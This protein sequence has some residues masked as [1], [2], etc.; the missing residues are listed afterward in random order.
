MCSSEKSQG[1][2]QSYQGALTVEAWNWL[3]LLLKPKWYIDNKL[4]DFQQFCSNSKA[5]TLGALWFRKLCVDFQRFQA[6]VFC[7]RAYSKTQ[8]PQ[9]IFRSLFLKVLSLFDFEH[10]PKHFVCSRQS[11]QGVAQSYQGALTVEAWNWLSLLL[12]PKW[13]IDNKLIDF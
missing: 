7:H 1:V 13:Y 10:F 6:F 4:I 8:K 11:S 3:F 9:K 12:K 5:L 2:A